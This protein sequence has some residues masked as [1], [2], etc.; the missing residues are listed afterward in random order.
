MKPVRN[1]L[2]ACVSALVLCAC[3]GGDS[4]DIAEPGVRL[5]HAS[6]IATDVSLYRESNGLVIVADA[7]YPYASDY[8]DVESGLSDW[9]VRTAVGGVIV[10]TVTI[11]A[12]RGKKY[13]VV[14][15]PDSAVTNS[16]YLIMD[17][18]EKPI[19][20]DSTR[21][22]V[23]NA[24]YATGDVD[25]YM[26]SIGTNIAD[27]GVD[28]LI[29]GIESKTAGPPS[30]EDSVDLPAGDFQVTLTAAGTKTILFTGKLSIGPD[31]DLL[32]VAVPIVPVL[33]GIQV[34]AKIEGDAGMTEVLPC[35]AVPSP[36]VPLCS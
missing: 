12:E 33:G 34:F 25:V 9:T 32:L 35:A 3:G 19:G 1:L 10:D 29:A 23:F 18:Y 13:S 6:P 22:R 7:A 31:R 8:I 24:T 11:D 26:N 16:A 27:P 21:L 5:V 4:L 2:A 36:P 17:P 20:S 15:A 28:P 30:G 14:V